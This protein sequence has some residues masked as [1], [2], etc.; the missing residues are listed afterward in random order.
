MGLIF[1]LSSQ[2]E[3]LPE[4]TS[5]VWDKALHAIEYAGLSVLTF[6]AFNGERLRGPAAALATVAIVSAFGA[7]DEWHQSFVPLRD[8]DVLDW[9]VDSGSAIAAAIASA[10]AISM[11]SRRRRRPPR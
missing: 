2:S 4:L 11:A 8:A 10:A 9:M 1:Y 3:P 5:R 7:S 6:R